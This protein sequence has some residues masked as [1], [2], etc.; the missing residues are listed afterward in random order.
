MIVFMFVNFTVQKK[1]DFWTYPSFTTIIS[2]VAQGHT[3][4]NKIKTIMPPDTF[5]KYQKPIIDAGFLKVTNIRKDYDPKKHKRKTLSKE[6]YEYEVNTELLIGKLKEL[7]RQDVQQTLVRLKSKK[8]SQKKSIEQLRIKQRRYLKEKNMRAKKDKL[9]HLNE[10]KDKINVYDWKQHILGLEIK[11]R[12]RFI[13]NITKEVKF[14]ESNWIKGKNTDYKLRRKRFWDI[15]DEEKELLIAAFKTLLI[16][17]TIPAD[18]IAP[19]ID[20]V[21][22]VLEQIRL[23]RLNFA[24]QCYRE[25]LK[26]EV[27][28]DSHIKTD[29]PMEF[30]RHN[31]KQRI[32]NL[33]GHLDPR[34]VRIFTYN[35]YLEWVNRIL[36]QYRSFIGG[37]AK[38]ST[39]K[40]SKRILVLCDDLDKYIDCFSSV[41]AQ[42]VQKTRED[43]IGKGLAHV[44]YPFFGEVKNFYHELHYSLSGYVDLLRV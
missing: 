11:R 44:E 28:V 17:N 2:L 42:Q 16:T 10:Q 31:D 24:S 3:S 38:G 26:K 33:S 43:R 30:M 5:I 22:N 18:D 39:L 32:S 35:E 37:K 36:G 14:I 13:H 8:D 12:K 1:G 40:E 7:F 6:P 41:E 23:G 25:D 19:P 21:K 29:Q 27:S 34:S 4:A 20:L 15:T 9:T